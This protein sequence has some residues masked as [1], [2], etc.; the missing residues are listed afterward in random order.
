MLLCP[1]TAAHD[2]AA[3]PSFSCRL[4]SAPRSRRILAVGLCPF[5]QSHVNGV[6]PSFCSAPSP[7]ISFELGSTPQS[8]RSLTTSTCPNSAASDSG[9][10]PKR[11]PRKSGE[12]AFSKKRLTFSYLPAR[13]AS[14]S[15]TGLTGGRTGSAP[16]CNSKSTIDQCPSS[17]AQV[18]GVLPS[19]FS[20][21]SSPYTSLELASAP[22]LRRNFTT[23]SRPNSAA[24]EIGLR[25]Q[26]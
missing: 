15:A 10:Q 18:N 5:M 9:E 6:F 13:A 11:S 7:L 23:F 2:R 17:V 21:S 20:L 3:F 24:R 22:W 1:F 19:L 14:N 4:G 26:S 8:R 25:P 12:T 16:C